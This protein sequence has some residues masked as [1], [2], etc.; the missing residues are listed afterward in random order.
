MAPVS[1]RSAASAPLA[2]RAWHA[3]AVLTL[4]AAGLAVDAA[5]AADP[6]SL[7]AD[8]RRQLAE[9]GPWPP[10]PRVDPSNRVSGQP[11]A[12]TLGRQLFRDPR[13]SPVGY[14]GCVT[15]H[16]PDRAFTDRKARAHGLAD[17]PRNTPA[18]FNLGQQRWFGWAGAS[19]SLWMASVRP[20]L[21][22]RELGGNP[23]LVVQ[24][25]EREPELAACYRQVFQAAPGAAP[26]RTVVNVG[27]AIAAYVE[28]LVSGRTPFDDYRDAVQ[29]GDR[30]GERNYPAAA[31]RGMKLF[32]GR[33]GCVACHNGPNF[34]DGDFHPGA[35][36]VGDGGR[37]DDLHKL[38][39]SP[40]KLSGQHDDSP[41]RA[42]RGRTAADAGVDLQHRY[43]TPSL[44]NVATSGP[45]LHDGRAEQLAQAV[46]HAAPASG[47]ALAATEVEDLAAFLETLTDRHGERRPWVADEI[48]RCP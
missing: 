29:R 43:R 38:R 48:A 8:E 5:P 1:A 28:T 6:P 44:R 46:M 31:L 35:A 2:R 24:L 42:A 39:S 25:F 45:Y 18:L 14:I 22:P 32:V 36:S 11:L 19:D 33:A 12:I 20:I 41:R 37:L 17:L 10:S 16:Q 34:S 30:E 7:S 27:K 47:G 23:R 26:Q 15:C 3:C 40:L 9:L 21:D 13:M 4:A